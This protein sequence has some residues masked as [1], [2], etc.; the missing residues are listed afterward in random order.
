MAI[1]D[2]IKDL[3]SNKKT[4]ISNLQLPLVQVNEQGG[5][6]T[7]PLK[8]AQ[9]ELGL[10]QASTPLTVKDGLF[11][12]E[13]TQ[14]YQTFNPDTNKVEIGTL[15]NYKPGFFNDFASGFKENYTQGFDVNNLVP[16]N[17]GL[18]TKIGE[19]L[20]TLARFYDKP[21]GRMAVATG[22]SYLTGEQNPL[23]EGI[24]AYVG[25]NKRQTAD[26]VYRS[27][28][29]QMGM[30]DE[31]LNEIPGEITKEIF[32][33]VTSGMR[34]NNQRITYGQLAQFSPEVAQ[35]V[36]NNPELE[37]QYLPVN[38]ARDVYGLKR[39][40]AEG[41]MA[42]IA[43]EVAK[44][45]KETDLLGKPKPPSKIIHISEGGNSGTKPDKNTRPV[46]NDYVQ[47]QAPNGKIYKVPKADIQ[48]YINAGG[49]VIG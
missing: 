3:L 37:Y 46:Q 19:G 4:P 41:K 39:D 20:G 42:Q 10:K 1:N 25:R 23:Q 2:F 45:K 48:K 44:T 28:L 26:K 32:E 29:K 35:A 6:E 24:E 16:Q 36:A 12:R 9:A 47:M 49:K 31:E 18:A 21:I 22:L 40:S 14:D 7:D 30:T 43:A 5:L 8:M 15:T 17:K 33:G 11:G 27:Q 13:M 38:F 34:Y